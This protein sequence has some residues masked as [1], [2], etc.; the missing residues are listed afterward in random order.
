MVA[1]RISY[2]AH[3]PPYMRAR[4]ASQS[5][6]RHGLRGSDAVADTNAQQSL[7]VARVAWLLPESVDMRDRE[8]TS[9]AGVS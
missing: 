2:R 3:V 9:E 6:T 1:M 8:G 7:D 5:C 4:Y